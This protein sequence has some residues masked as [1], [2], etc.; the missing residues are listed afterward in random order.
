MGEF[1]TPIITPLP[2]LGRGT[3]MSAAPKLKF[4]NRGEGKVHK[5]WN[6]WIQITQIV[7]INHESSIHGGGELMSLS[8]SVKMCTNSSKTI[9]LI[10]QIFDTAFDPSSTMECW[11]HLC[12][13]LN[14]LTFE[15]IPWKIGCE[16]AYNFNNKCRWPSS[17][18]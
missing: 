11:G 7:D 17:V 18:L 9:T 8:F 10:A 12:Y 1:S 16:N 14:Y 13:S 15:Q 3:I 4:S 5:L 6:L 2:I